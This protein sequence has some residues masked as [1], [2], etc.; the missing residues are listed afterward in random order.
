MGLD[1]HHSHHPGGTGFG[2]IPGKSATSAT[3]ATDRHPAALKRP[4]ASSLRPTVNTPKSAQTLPAAESPAGL[5]PAQPARGGTTPPPHARAPVRATR[6]LARARVRA[7]VTRARR[8]GAAGAKSSSPPAVALA[9]TVLPTSAILYSNPLGRS[10]RAR[11]SS[12]VTGLRIGSDL[13]LG[14]AGNTDACHASLAVGLK[15]DRRHH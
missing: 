10:M 4:R 15:P 6:L 3:C 14:D 13:H 2:S 7:R 8:L 5:R 11:C 1:I 9:Y 12:P